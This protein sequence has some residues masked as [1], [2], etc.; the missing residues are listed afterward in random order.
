MK[1]VLGREQRAA[2]RRTAVVES[3]DEETGNTPATAKGKE[4]AAETEGNEDDDPPPAPKG[5]KAKAEEV[6]ENED[7]TA[8]AVAAERKRCAGLQAVGIQ[9]ERLDVEFNVTEAINKGMSVAKARENVLAAAA[10][11]DAPETIAIAVPKS[12]A[13]PGGSTLDAAGKAA[14]WKKALKRR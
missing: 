9:A 2:A 8:N 13:T 7:V 12:K 1:N 6:D 14:A 5:K 3:S 10:D 11:G 4:P